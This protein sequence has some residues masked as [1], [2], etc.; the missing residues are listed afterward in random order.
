MLGWVKEML[1]R[2]SPTS[3]CP[4]CHQPMTPLRRAD[5]PNESVTCTNPRCVF[6]L[7]PFRHTVAG[8]ELLRLSPVP[9][10]YRR[11]VSH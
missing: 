3:E 4:V 5:L 10:T 6:H 2:L 1:L 7:R 8:L 11:S 9:A